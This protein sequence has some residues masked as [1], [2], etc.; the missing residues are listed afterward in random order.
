MCLNR[1]IECPYF[2]IIETEPFML[3]SEASFEFYLARQIAWWQGNVKSSEYMYMLW[4]L[5]VSGKDFSLLCSLHEQHH[6]VGVW[7]A[8]STDQQQSVA[9][10]YLQHFTPRTAFSGCL[11]IKT[12]PRQPFIGLYHFVFDLIILRL[13]LSVRTQQPL[14]DHQLT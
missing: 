12:V 3:K 14:I 10:K 11:F 6:F 9:G 8:L 4:T 5:K 1:N 2:Q 7:H 13:W